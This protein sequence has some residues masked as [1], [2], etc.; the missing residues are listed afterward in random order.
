MGVAYCVGNLARIHSPEVSGVHK[1]S[2]ISGVS[3]F[4]FFFFP[5][6]VFSDPLEIELFVSIMSMQGYNMSEGAKRWG[7]TKQNTNYI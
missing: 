4:F 7:V 3:G 5:F 2:S 1:Q 6:K